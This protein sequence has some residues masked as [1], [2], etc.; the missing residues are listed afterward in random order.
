MLR[1]CSHRRIRALAFSTRE[2]IIAV[3]FANSI[4]M[5]RE[6][7]ELR[8]ARAL[9]LQY[10]PACQ[11]ALAV[12]VDSMRVTAPRLAIVVVVN[13]GADLM[14]YAVAFARRLDAEMLALV[15]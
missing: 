13:H 10:A 12:L 15:T 2:A 6:R 8:G 7:M 5:V 9:I 14:P 1:H 3:A 4:E 11:H